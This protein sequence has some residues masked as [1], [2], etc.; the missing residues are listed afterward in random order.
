MDL[1]IEKVTIIGL[2]LMGGSFGLALRKRGLFTEITGYDQD[3]E[4]CRQAVAIGAVHKISNNFEEA[5]IDSDLVV[6]ATPV[7]HII[8]YLDILPKAATKPCLVTDLGS[9]KKEI[10]EK[11]STLPAHIDAVGGHPMCGGFTPGIKNANADL[12]QGKV[13]IICPVKTKN[14]LSKEVLEKIAASIGSIPIVMDETSHDRRVGAV[15]HLPYFMSTLL[16]Q[17]AIQQ[18][19]KDPEMKKVAAGSFKM[20]TSLSLGSEEMWT[21]IFL[22]N[23]SNLTE[24]L[25]T[26]K[27]SIDQWITFLERDDRESVKRDLKRVRNQRIQLDK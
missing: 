20:V 9:T 12:F 4:A 22:S 16:M 10:V 7:S 19:E 25:Q 8:S 26:S 14:D 15:S 27:E 18:F 5:V 6:L 17:V 13:F 11:M 2:G 24:L 3:G 21:D 1:Q 23:Q